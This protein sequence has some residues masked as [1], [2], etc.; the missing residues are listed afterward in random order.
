MTLM[1]FPG[2]IP[3]GK[4]PGN[5]TSRTQLKFSNNLFIFQNHF[6][7]LPNQLPCEY[8]PHLREPR[9]NLFNLVKLHLWLKGEF[10]SQLGRTLFMIGYKGCSVTASKIKCYYQLYTSSG[11]QD[12]QL[13]RSDTLASKYII[14]KN[15]ALS[16]TYRQGQNTTHNY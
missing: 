9:I 13:D 8:Y 12:Y 6:S 14:E 10:S 7:Y 5:I 2:K 1:K 16:S 4:S 11:Y 3:V 15:L